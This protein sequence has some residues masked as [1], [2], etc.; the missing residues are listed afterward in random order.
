MVKIKLLFFGKAKDLVGSKEATLDLNEMLNYDSK[1]LIDTIIQNHQKLECIRDT[2]QL[3]LNE[4]YLNEN[5][6]YQLKD[7]DEIAVIPP[8]SG[9]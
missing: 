2:I 7:Y 8:I 1:F 6:T 5:E 4:C 3:A 9:G